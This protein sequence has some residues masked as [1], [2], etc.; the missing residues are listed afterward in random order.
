MAQQ[1]PVFCEDC[2]KVFMGGPNAFFCPKC[3]KMRVSKAARE[4][5]IKRNLN[6]IGNDAYSE[7]RAIDRRE[8]G[9][10]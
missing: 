4:N 5:A 3:R 7:Q 9:R 10:K 1:A 8:A 2:G 6:K